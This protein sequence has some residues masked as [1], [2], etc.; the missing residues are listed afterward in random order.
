MTGN[1]NA[2]QLSSTSHNT[3]VLCEGN[4]QLIVDFQFT[5]DKCVIV[6]I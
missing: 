4:N 5:L 1:D 6:K 2:L 3:V